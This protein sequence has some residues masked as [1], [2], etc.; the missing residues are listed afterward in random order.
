MSLMVRFNNNQKKESSHEEILEKKKNS[1]KKDSKCI[2]NRTPMKTKVKKRT[3][4]KDQ[5]K[6]SRM[7]MTMI[8][9]FEDQSPHIKSI[10]LDEYLI[11]G[12]SMLV[13]LSANEYIVHIGSFFLVRCNRN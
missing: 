9:I 4:R 3:M 12:I 1:H 5:G 13:S 6:K 8:V 11:N 10:N 7:K 2:K